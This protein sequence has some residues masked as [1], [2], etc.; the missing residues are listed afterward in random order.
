MKIKVENFQSI[1]NAEIEVEGLTVICGDNSI[2][3]SALARAFN[4]VFTNLR[5]NAHVRKGEP[6]LCVCDL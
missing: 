6:Y 1:K 5:G 3:K 2:G 4:G